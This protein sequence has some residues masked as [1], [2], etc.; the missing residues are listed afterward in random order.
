MS[1]VL[2]DFVFIYCHKD[3][4]C[5]TEWQGVAVLERQHL[6]R[7]KIITFSKVLGIYSPK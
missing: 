1:I 6:D 4:R 7:D 3:A 5:D 2:K